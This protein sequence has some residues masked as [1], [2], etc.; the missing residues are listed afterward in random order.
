MTFDLD[1]QDEFNQII[2]DPNSVLEADKDFTQDVFD[3]THSNV[4][5]AIPKNGD[6]PDEYTRAARCVRER[7][8]CRSQVR[9]GNKDG[10]PISTAKKNP[11]LDPRM[12]E[13]EYPDWH[14]APLVAKAIADIKYKFI[15]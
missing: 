10:F 4:E 8:D 7:M 15:F 11:I 5:P 6:E 2:D 1:F 9:E 3:D 12:Y 14:K 13:V